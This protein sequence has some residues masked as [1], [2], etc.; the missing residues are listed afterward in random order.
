[1]VTRKVLNAHFNGMTDTLDW[2]AQIAEFAW[3]VE[4]DRKCVISPD[5]DGFLSAMLMVK[6][7][8]WTVKGYYD[9]KSL[10]LEKGTSPAECVFLDVEIARDQV[11][12]I[13]HHWLLRHTASAEMWGAWKNCFNPNIRRDEMSGTGQAKYAPWTY[14][15]R[16][17]PFGTVHLL[18]GFL[19]QDGTSAA[20][21]SQDALAPVLF[22]DGTCQNMFRYPE[23]CRDWLRYLGADQPG[24]VLNDYFSASGKGVLDLMKTMHQ[25]YDQRDAIGQRCDRLRVY[26][27]QSPWRIDPNDDTLLAIAEAT[28]G[29]LTAF[30]EMCGEKTG[31]GYDP[32]DWAWNTLERTEFD[33]RQKPDAN[34]AETA[35]T[36]DA[37]MLAANPL[38][39]AW[40]ATDRLEC[41]LPTAAADLP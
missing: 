2:A 14:F 15:P 22:A 35:G 34:T 27:Q 24:T 1:M 7:R 41:T 40:T 16:K 18:L 36:C 37:S 11:Q 30:L 33:K 17:Y 26:R 8:D 29:K 12:S 25:F 19:E 6:H 23:N 21:A 5:A 31:W 13:G 10:L 3:L 38:S 4:R 9:G 28:E 39:W 32:A 20:P